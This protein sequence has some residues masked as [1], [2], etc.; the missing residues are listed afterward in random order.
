V[1]DDLALISG[2]SKG[3]GRSTAIMLAD[4]GFTILATAR[5]RQDLQ[6]LQAE[7][8]ENG[9]KCEYLCT[10]LSAAAG[11]RK[12][13]DLTKS[14]QKP[15]SILVHC[16]GMAKVGKIESYSEKA[17]KETLAINLTAPFL[18]TKA[19]IPI[20]GKPSHIFFINSVA[21][22]QVFTEWGAYAVSKWGL[23]ALADTLRLELAGSGIKVTSIFPSSVDTTLHDNLPY[24]WDRRQMLRDTDVAKAIILC[25]QQS[26]KIQVREIDLENL[27]GTF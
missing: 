17:W 23:R 8:R 14:I 24:K 6:N 5:N 15:L 12:I 26:D 3:I 16:A 18:L 7:I 25:F 20:L 19:C 27:A 10:D 2:A 1:R 4:L 9:G 13:T 21:G 22:K 11:I